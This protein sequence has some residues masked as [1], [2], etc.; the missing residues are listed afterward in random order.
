MQQEKS[1]ISEEQMNEMIDE[2]PH[3]GKYIREE[4]NLKNK[5]DEKLKNY[6]ENIERLESEKKEIAKSISE[7]YR[8]ATASGFDSKIIRK[9]IAIRKRDKAELQEE[10]YIMQ[11]YA[12]SLQM[13]LF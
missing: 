13:E 1:L 6:V 8:D 2:N 7:N 12:E 4:C 10:A 5:V 11:T 9:L 3:L